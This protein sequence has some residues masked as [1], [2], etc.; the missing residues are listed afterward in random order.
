MS[1]EKRERKR[2]ETPYAQKLY[3]LELAMEEEAEELAGFLRG[4]V[5]E[6]REE[7]EP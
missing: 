2:L 1:R 6:P 4:E 5:P 7:V 3:E